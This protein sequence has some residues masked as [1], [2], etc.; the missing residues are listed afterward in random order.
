MKRFVRYGIIPVGIFFI[1]LIVTVILIPILINVQKYVPEIERHISEATGRSF[2]L[3]PDLGVSFFPWLSISFSDM[4]I[5]NPPGFMDDDFIKIRTFEARIRV[6]PLLRKQIEISRFVVGGLAVNL[7]KNGSGQVN[8]G[9]GEEAEKSKGSG[10]PAVW[11]LGLLSKQLSFA[12]LA[13]T[14]GQVKWN[15]RTR[16]VQYHVEDIMLLLNDFSHDRPVSLDC[17]AT[18]NGRQ[19]AVEGK[20]GPIIK[21]DNQGPLPV[22]IAF[23]V[24]EKLRGQM[25]GKITQKDMAP[26]FD[27]SLRLSPFALPDFFSVCGLPFPLE[28]KDSEMFSKSTLEFMVHGDAEKIAIEKGLA[29][30]DGSKLNFSLLA[31]DFKSPQVN[32]SLELDRIDLDR[33][34]PLSIADVQFTEKVTGQEEQA[35]AEHLTWKDFALDGVIKVGA[36]KI[37]GGTLTEIH[38]PLRVQDGIFTVAPATLKTSGGQAEA[39]FTLDLQAAVPT[40]QA[41]LKAQDLKAETLLHDFTGSDYLYGTLS[42]ELALQF[43]GDTLETMKKNLSGEVTLLVRDGALPGVNFCRMPEINEIRPQSAVSGDASGEKAQ[44]DFTEAKSVFSITH[45]LVQLHETSLFAPDCS[46]QV[47]GTADIVQQQLNLQMETGFVTTVVGKGGRQEKVEHSSLFSIS[48]T[49]SEPELKNHKAPAGGGTTGGRNNVKQ[50]VAQK[51][52]SPGDDDVKN[53]VGKDLVDPAVVAQRFRLQ[54][55][56]LRRSEMKK[57]FPVGTGKIRVGDLREEATH[58]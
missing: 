14:D 55:E 23:S 11:S 36:L 43:A 41:T 27:L 1:L 22:D 52:S 8:W 2:S 57:K 56:I 48:G 39:S 38:L 31:Q 24:A 29:T 13:V 49:F 16:N 25:S 9:F 7:E 12:L 19:V 21:N 47:S 26:N 20:V 54:P 37:H 35:M 33:Y 32:F 18:I 6:L 10:P 15:D 45:G 46:L 4:K 58:Q 34:L 40:I 30:L 42:S 5:G 50:L 28:I 17:K 53:L 51:L 44:T 3:G